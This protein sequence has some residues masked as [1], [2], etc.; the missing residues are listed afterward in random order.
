MI[1]RPP[2][3]TLFP[4]TTLF[5]S[6]IEQLVIAHHARRVTVQ[7]VVDEAAGAR[8][9]ARD[10]ARVDRRRIQP[11]RLLRGVCKLRGERED[12]YE[13]FHFEV[14]LSG[15][16]RHLSVF[17]YHGIRKKNRKYTAVP[18]CAASVRPSVTD[19]VPR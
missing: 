8:L 10:I 2:R 1:R 17:E 9:Q 14:I 3:S 13:R 4:Y 19:S 15:S 5:R 6:Q 16:G 7:A 12:N 11:D 18:T